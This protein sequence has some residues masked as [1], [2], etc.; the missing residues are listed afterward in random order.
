M[1]DAEMMLVS[2]LVFLAVL[3]GLACWVAD[4]RGMAEQERW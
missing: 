1:T 4:Q 3:L 2:L